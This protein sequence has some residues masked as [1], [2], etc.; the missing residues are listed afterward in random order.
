[1]VKNG[2][3]RMLNKLKK[4]KNEC[5][6]AAGKY[7]GLKLFTEIQPLFKSVAVKQAA[8]K[9]FKFLILCIL[10]ACLF[11]SSFGCARL[12]FLPGISSGYY[13]WKDSAEKIHIA[14][15]MERNQS[16]FEGIVATDGVISVLDRINFT[17][18]DVISLSS[19][20]NRLEFNA[21]IAEKEMSQ[22]LVI[23]ITNYNYIEFDLKING[24]YD[25]ERTHVGEYLANPETAV[26]RIDRDYFSTLKNIPFYKKHP[27]SAFF[28]KLSAD[29]VFVI[30]FIFIIGV[31][32]IEIIRITALR[33]KKKYNWYLILCYGVLI[34][35]IA[36]IYLFLTRFS[37]I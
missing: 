37:F 33:K 10:T 13:I 23:D 31:V 17:D 26:F 18:D 16:T 21:K 2:N 15:G 5:N 19:E 20:K 1:M 22:E 8:V 14:W 6:Q 32:V 12:M 4:L 3:Y 35:V 11:M 9:S 28:Y 27:W 24:G 30:F 36:G 7:F 34:L 29:I 25:L